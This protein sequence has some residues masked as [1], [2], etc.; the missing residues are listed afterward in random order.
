MYT[1]ETA[2]KRGTDHPAGLYLWQIEPEVRAMPAV[3]VQ[4]TTGRTG[5]WEQI[6]H[7]SV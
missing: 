4:V 1:K 6:G 5:S 7:V 2:S 3:P